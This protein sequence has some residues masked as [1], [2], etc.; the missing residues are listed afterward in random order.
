MITQKLD[1]NDSVFGFVS[2]WVNELNKNVSKLYVLPLYKGKYELDKDISV[3]SLEKEKKQNKFFYIINL[4]RVVLPL[5]Y[6]KKIDGIFVHQGGLYPL[7]LWLPRILFGVK[8]Y[9]WKVHSIIDL[10]MKMNILFANKI[11]T[12]SKS[13]FKNSNKKKIIILGHGIDTELFKNKQKKKEKT[14]VVVGRIA[15][16]KR[17]KEIIVIFYNVLKD[18]RFKD[19]RLEFYGVPITKEGEIYLTELKTLVKHINLE[20]KV[21]F[22]GKVNFKQLPEIYNYAKLSLNI[23]NIGS[24]DKVILESMACETPCIMSTNAILNQLGDK[25]NLIYSEEANEIKHLIIRIINLNDNEYD[26]LGVELRKIVVRKHS[27]RDL[28]KNIANEFKKY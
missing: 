25:K 5:L 9:Q 16:I 1:K 14:I 6:K 23:G 27:L 26:R 22:R 3:F 24:L 15:K 4:Y 10:N 2:E 11:I 21:F 8:L 13:C 12:S 17:L 28:M 18:N 7:L 20:E 19:Y